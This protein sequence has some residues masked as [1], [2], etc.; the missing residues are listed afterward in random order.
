M[1]SSAPAAPTGRIAWLDLARAAAIVLVVVYH[2]ASGAGYD[3]L[4]RDGGAAGYWWSS[5]NI[6]LAPIPMNLFFLISGMFAVRAVHRPFARVV[7]PRIL[8]MAWPYLL[9]SAVFAVTAWTRYA[10]EDPVGY[11]RSQ[12]EATL[13]VMGP[14]WFIAVLPVFFLAARLGRDRPRLLLA[15]ALAVYLLAWPL[16][17][18]MLTQEWIPALVSE[19]LYRFTIYAVWYLGGFVLRDRIIALVGGI[20]A[21]R[22]LLILG[23]FAVVTATMFFGQYAPLLERAL[24]AAASLTGVL[25]V[26][27]LLPRAASS[28]PIARA[29]SLV[30]SR[31]LEIYMIHPLVLNAVVVLYPGSAL[32]AALHGTWT[33]DLLLIPAVSA[34]S[35]GAGLLAHTLAARPGLGWLFEFPRA[36][37]RNTTT[38]GARPGSP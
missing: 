31:T 37:E 4:P 12:A 24:H 34:L 32:D 20:G 18:L 8:D 7:R 16:K 36:R 22:G 17:M 15:A 14:Y 11:M 1:S 6:M 3:L 2:V 29:G 28:A 10:P 19:G 23:L 5:V 30:G 27:A 25:G 13:V 26:M 35:L 9:W 38:G 33:A 21:L